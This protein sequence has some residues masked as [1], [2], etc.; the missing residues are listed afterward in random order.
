MK[1]R[2]FV[3]GSILDRF[4]EGF[5]SVFGSPNPRFL[6]FFRCFFDVIFEARSEGSKIEPK[7]Q[8]EASGRQVKN[9]EG[10]RANPEGRRAFGQEAQGEEFK[11]GVAPLQDRTT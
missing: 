2:V 3:G 10:R 7:G 5:G 9:P 6:H 4:W 11:E 8:Q 1:N